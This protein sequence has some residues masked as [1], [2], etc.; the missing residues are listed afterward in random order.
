MIPVGRSAIDRAGIAELHGLSWRQARRVRP[1]AQPEHPAPITPGRP[2]NGRPQLW[3]F[4]QSEQFARGQQV[5]PLPAGSIHDRDLLDRREA[6]EQAGV[7]P[8][9]W[10]R[11]MYRDR[12]PPADEH[13]LGGT[14]WYRGTVEDYRAGRTTPRRGGGRPA[15]RGESV[16]RGEL[17]QRVRELLREAVETR[18]PMST[19][20]IARRLGIHYTTAH[21]HMAAVRAEGSDGPTSER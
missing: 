9:A 4:E 3:D 18:V 19:A 21:R 8:V 11:D 12:V 14:F 17:R 2:T 10:E 13:I 15:G 16:P 7:D 20:E 1:W 6:A 5:T